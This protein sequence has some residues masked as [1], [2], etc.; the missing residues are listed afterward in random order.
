[1]KLKIIV[2]LLFLQCFSVF[3][4]AQTT[5]TPLNTTILNDSGHYK[6]VR[7]AG[8]FRSQ[9]QFKKLTRVELEILQV[10]R[11]RITGS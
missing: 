9:T 10:V 8:I 6:N 11:D 5:D 1:M 7:F 4:H 3:G 2:G